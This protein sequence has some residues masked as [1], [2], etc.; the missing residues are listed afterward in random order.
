MSGAG[1]LSKIGAGTLI[2]TG[3][4]TYSG[5]TT[6]SV[7]TLQGDT[8]SL[9]GNIANAT[10]VVFDQAGSGTYAG[11]M[12]GAGA[13]TKIGAGTLIMTGANTYG[14][15]TTVSVGTLQ[16]DST[17]LQGNIANATSVVF[18]QAGSGTYAGVMSGAGALT[19]IGAG[20]LILTGMNNYSG[21][22]TVVAGTLQGNTTSLQGNIVDDASVVFDQAGS[23]TYAG[24]MSGTGFLIKENVGTLALTAV[25][26]YQG[27]TTING[28]TLELSG[29]GSLDSTKPVNVNSSTSVFSIAALSGSSTTIGDLMGV[30]GS[31][32][33]LG[34]KT[35]EFGTGTP[36]ITFEGNIID[37][38]LGGSWIKQGTGTVILT[39]A[40]SNTGSVL[41]SGGTLV[42]NGTLGGGGP[43]NVASGVTLQ[44]TGTITKDVTV[45]GTLSPGNS[46]GTIHLVGAQTLAA[47]SKLVIELNPTSTDLVDIVGTLNIQ[48]PATLELMPDF[49]IYPAPISYTIVHT[50]AGIT[51]TFS[52]VTSTL[53]LFNTNSVVQTFSD[54]MLVLQTGF[55]PFTDLVHHGN[56]GAV[57]SCLDALT[58]FPCS[59][60]SMMI[61][62]LRF[63]PDVSDL[64]NALNLL[65]PSLFTSL[66]IAQENATL[67]MRNAIYDRLEEPLHSCLPADLDENKNLSFWIS[68][69]GAHT[70][71]KNT[72]N[73]PG[74]LANSPGAF[75]GLDAKFGKQSYFGGGLGYTYTHLKWKQSRGHSHQQTAYGSLYGRWGTSRIFL[76][77]ALMGGYNFYS[78]RRNIAFGDIDPVKTVASGSHQGGEGAAS[79]KSGL[80]FYFGRNGMLVPFLALDYIFIHENGFKENGAKS[81]DL[82]IKSKNSDLLNTE[83]GIDLSYCFLSAENCYTPFIKLSAIRESRFHGQKEK[84]SFDCG[85]DFTV[86]GYYP[87]RTLGAV[88]IGFDTLFS[89]NA[90]TLSYQGKFA[91]NYSD[92]SFYAE[93]KRQF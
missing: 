1:T 16:G 93:Y 72:R 60:L 87:S 78:T 49:G 41:V 48:Q 58:D 79:V 38:G 6:V 9:Q 62:V 37:G 17:S 25:N 81:L 31:S 53:P 46:I 63:I 70:N 86:K 32:V 10:S 47:G 59:N 12:S 89:D 4:N 73:E 13:L 7:G 77:S 85:C 54:I 34:A 21:G 88:A 67:Y 83:G 52:T 26:T 92:N 36:I 30:P 43:M 19:K 74:F 69:I 51:G 35:L 64:E 42:V 28:G 45:N 3:A 2:L 71:Q 15:G 75:M 44:G 50:T 57:A 66:A 91:R 82:K 11:I 68:A 20:T 18:D 61:A 33:A 8:T 29:S 90:L 65:Q 76:Q 23:G 24:V 55:L 27:G 56:A 14:G 22:T 80:N 39:G 84:A 40:N 5:G